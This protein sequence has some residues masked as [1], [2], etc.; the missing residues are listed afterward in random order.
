MRFGVLASSLLH[1]AAVGAAFITLPDAVRTKIEAE[2][3]IPIELIV[4]AEDALKT[5]VPAAA[6]EIE[7]EPEPAPE[8]APAPE[9][10]PQEPAPEPE[11]EPEPIVLPP[12][13]E[14]EEPEPEEPEPAPEPEPE[15][16]KP[17]PKKPPEPDPLDFDRLTA[18]VDKAKDNTPS[19]KGP[20][21]PAPQIQGEQRNAIGAGDR[22]A[23]SD[24]T[25]IRA[26]IS[27]CWN[28]S[29]IIGAPEPEKLRVLLEVRLKR[30]G[31]LVEPPDVLNARQINFSGNRFW[32]VA[33]QNAVRAVIQCQP[34]DFL[35]VDRYDAWKELELNFDPT[36]MAGF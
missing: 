23:A 29:A 27:R 8:P 24:I 12:E 19:P 2:P 4:D 20:E 32:K 33:E 25:K 15:P 16:P 9:P 21:G 18:L 36:Q 7:P 22:L 6:P 13:P 28:A 34:Y 35:A 26:A 30:D 14:P 31:T 11:P 5:S 3:Y 10:V 17:A 1:G